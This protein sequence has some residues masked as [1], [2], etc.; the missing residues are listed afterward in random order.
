MSV[1]PRGRKGIYSYSFQLEGVA[2]F[3]TTGCTSKRDALAFEADAR[4]Q[5]IKALAL[6][7]A[8]RS[9]ALTLDAALER[10]WQEVGQHYT[11]TYG[12][13]VETALAWLL[14]KSGIGGNTL[15]RDIGPNRI[16]EAIARRRGEG[17]SN[18]TVNRTVVELLRLL[19][20]R[21]RKHW[22]QDVAEIE[23]KKLM[24]AEPKERIKAL[25]SHEEPLLM[26]AMRE[27]YLPAIQFMLKSGFRKREVVN[28][29]KTDIDWGNRIIAVIGKGGKPATIP[30]STEL[31]EILWPLMN[32]PSEYVFT[33]VAKATRAVKGSYII[34]TLI[35]GERYP[36]TYSGLATAW[37]RFGPSKAGIADFHL[38]DLRHTAAT[39]L[40]RGGKANIKVVQ[41]LLR[42]ENIATT[43][44]YMH[45]YDDDVLQAMEAETESR[46]N[47][48]QIP[49]QVMQ[50]K[51]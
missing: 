45:A 38:H 50:K 27:D 6:R 31:R 34:T 37:R 14:E 11:G 2:F 44:K 22:E 39:R 12:K 25:K 42:H 29:K 40:A 51:A 9:G 1:F 20:I 16:S 49:L 47:P 24:L 41:R 26:D 35:R 48:L 23:W 21:A 10:L 43:A 3:G 4:R 32:H 13:T 18:A 7:K 17:V 15:L 36:I 46:Q 33:Y 5:K 8:S 19:F 30:L 28:L